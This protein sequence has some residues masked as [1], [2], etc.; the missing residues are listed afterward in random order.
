MI[1]KDKIVE[2]W[3]R[4]EQ[5][6]TEPDMP[7]TVDKAEPVEPKNDLTVKTDSSSEFHEKDS[8]I[9]LKVVRPENYTEV[10]AVA[11]YL[12]DGCTVFLNMEQLDRSVITRMLDFLRG[13]T[14]ATNG[15]IKKS[16]A[17]TYIITPNNVDI[18]DEKPV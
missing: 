8:A 4:R 7:S 2:W 10:A 17:T 12:L 6:N 11:D 1:M 3:S 18:S 16:S 14:Y 9:E 15:Q 5:K 13:V